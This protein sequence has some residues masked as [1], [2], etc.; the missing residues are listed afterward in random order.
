MNN[1]F[2]L[3]IECDDEFMSMPGQVEVTLS[4]EAKDIIRKAAR[5][6]KEDGASEVRYA[7][8]AGWPEDDDEPGDATIHRV[9]CVELVIEG[10]VASK[11]V[12]QVRVTGLDKY[13]PARVWS[14]AL[15]RDVVEQ[16]I[17][18]GNGAGS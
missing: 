8:S 7:F 10:S 15:P 17:N 2:L 1:S 16:I 14:E 13:S 5:A 18:E 9:E 6:I 11:E 12:R 4:H 3:N